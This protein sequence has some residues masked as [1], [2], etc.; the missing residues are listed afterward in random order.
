MRRLGISQLVLWSVLC[1]P[2][3]YATNFWQR[4]AEVGTVTVHIHWVTLDELKAAALRLGKRPQARPMGF[5][6]LRK[7]VETGAYVCDI[8]MPS[9]PTRV[10][11]RVTNL[12]GHEFAHCVGFSHE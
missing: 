3:A 8:Y 6:V 2:A 9:E 1:A 5:S 10:D 12:L 11:D 4:A 7:N